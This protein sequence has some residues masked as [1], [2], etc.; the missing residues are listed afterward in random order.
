[1]SKQCKQRKNYIC[2]TYNM[3]FTE[4]QADT[5]QN[6]HLAEV[7]A[8]GYASAN[9]AIMNMSTGDNCDVLQKNE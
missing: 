7:A 9:C 8:S 6:T 1:M 4:Q 2:Y 5:E 3:V